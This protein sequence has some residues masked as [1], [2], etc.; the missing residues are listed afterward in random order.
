[1]K[2]IHQNYVCKNHEIV[3]VPNYLIGLIDFKFNQ[4]GSRKLFPVGK[5]Y[6]CVKKSPNTPKVQERINN[7]ITDCFQKAS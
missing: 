3:L 4:E 7:I 1:M 6:N 5:A 2:V